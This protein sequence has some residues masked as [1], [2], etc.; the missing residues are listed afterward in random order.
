[1][2]LARFHYKKTG[3][4]LSFVPMYLAPKRKTIYYGHPI[5]F[6]P[7][8]PIAEERERICR[9]LMDSITAIA[10]SLPE[11]TV[12]PY[13]NVSKKHY[14]KNIPLEVYDGTQTTL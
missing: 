14:P 3:V 2:D 6:R 4:T 10:V 11:H 5:A 1:M 8:A 7:D 9:D 13:P 12:I